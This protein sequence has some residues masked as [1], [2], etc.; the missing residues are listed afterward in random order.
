LLVRGEATD[1][2]C[3]YSLLVSAEPIRLNCPDHVQRIDRFSV[4]RNGAFAV[5][6]AADGVR[7]LSDRADR[8]A[9]PWVQLGPEQTRVPP[10]LTPAKAEELP[11]E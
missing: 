10:D 5:W 6:F 11:P 9:R 3:A 4:W 2:D 8:G 1:D 7:V